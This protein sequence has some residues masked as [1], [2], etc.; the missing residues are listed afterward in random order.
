MVGEAQE[1]V[2]DA[3]VGHVRV[4]H[5]RRR[6]LQARRAEQRARAARPAH[7]GEHRARVAH[8]RERQPR[9]VVGNVAVVRDDEPLA[10]RVDDDGR[11]RRT[12][13]GQAAEILRVDAVGRE[14]LRH[15]R[16]GGVIA[17]AAPERDAAA[18]ARDGA[19]GV[20]RHAAA[21]L[22]V[23]AR[24]HLGRER[25]NRVDRVDAVERGVPEADD[26]ERSPGH[27]RR[28]GVS[29]GRR[30][31][32]RHEGST[33]WPLRPRSI[34]STT[35]RRTASRRS[36]T[37]A[38]AL[39]LPARG[40]R[41]A[42]PSYRGAGGARGSR[43]RGTARRR[44]TRACARARVQGRAVLLVRPLVHAPSSG[45][46]WVARARPGRLTDG[47]RGTKDHAAGPF[48]RRSTRKSTNARTFADRWRRDG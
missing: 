20:G 3:A 11:L 29:I 41:A 39:R 36:S 47:D 27:A 43:H 16:A 46:A 30:A 17:G 13:A 25:R 23:R 44:G 18:Q 15:R 2:D 5:A 38:C 34:S 28:H 8:A 32:P 7:V 21:H 6:R 45:D 9:R 33:L 22:A 37:A 48:G 1:L 10:A 40:Q 26:V 42:D 35:S 24:A 31:R 19:R 4:E 12:A 14:L